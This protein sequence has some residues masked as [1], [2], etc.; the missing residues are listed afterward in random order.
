MLFKPIKLWQTGFPTCNE[1][2]QVRDCFDK[3]QRDI[4]VLAGIYSALQHQCI[5]YRLAARVVIEENIRLR[6]RRLGRKLG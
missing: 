6:L 3:L 5:G 4:L 2:F 1:I